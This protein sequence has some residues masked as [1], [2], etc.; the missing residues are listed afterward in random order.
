[1]LKDG[2]D[3]SLGGLKNLN[4]EVSEDVLAGGCVI[5]TEWN[6][7]DAGLQTQLDSMVEAL[8]GKKKKASTEE[9]EVKEGSEITEKSS[10]IEAKAT[11]EGSPDAKTPTPNNEVSKE[12]K[13]DTGEPPKG[14]S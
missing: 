6:K 14:E 11:D 2:L 7:I 1:M 4:V 9:S 10:E 13:E 8:F 3:K 5:E 12:T